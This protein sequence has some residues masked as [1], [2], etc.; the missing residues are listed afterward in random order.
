MKDSRTPVRSILCLILVLIPGLAGA[1]LQEDADQYMAD[2]RWDDAAV[3]Y[4][5]LLRE[6]ET[7]ANNWFNLARAYQES[8]N[9]SA[10]RPAYENAIT[11]GYQPAARAHFYFARAL[12]LLNDPAG[13]LNQL[14]EVARLGG[15]G[16]QTV[17]N[18]PEFEPLTGDPRF[19]AVIEAL[20]P[21]NTQEFR[22]FDFWLGQWDVT[23]AGS[24]QPS[25]ENDITSIHGGCVV[26]EQYTSGFFTGMSLNFYDATTQ[27]W[28][29]TWMSNAGGALFLQGGINAKGAMVMSDENL[30]VST[31]AGSI[32]RITWTPNPDG[33]VRQ[34]WQNSS[35]RGATWT[36]I[37]DGTYT[38]KK[39]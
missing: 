17:Q 31:A 11:F 37:F 30:P 16:Y 36:V 19:M 10:A 13:A 22:Q 1:G 9:Y 5:A 8:G 3:A 6:D 18:A 34:F 38:K 26:L 15:P 32:N 4:A 12:M 29:Q 25:A 35:D 23:S 39:E 27:S 33:S 20:K 7:V 21:C 14:E 2:A 28:H 24:V